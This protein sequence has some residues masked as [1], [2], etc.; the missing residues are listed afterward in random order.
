VREQGRRVI[1]KTLDSVPA[2]KEPA[3]R[4]GDAAWP[5]FLY[6]NDVR[7]WRVLFTKFTRYQVCLCDAAGSLLA[8]GHTLPIPWDGT[9]DDLPQ[10]I[11]SIIQRAI[12]AH[13]DSEIPKVLAALAAIVAPPHQGRG[14]SSQL[15]RAMTS[16]AVRY[17]LSGLIAP[18]RPTLKSLYP[19][20]SMQRY[21]TYTR[22]DGS[23][24]DPWIRVHWR[25]G[26]RQLAI[27]PKTL[28]V[29]GTVSEWE[30]W[31][32]HRFPK[33]GSYLVPGALEPITIDLDL[34]LGRY[35]EPN[36]WMHHRV[37]VKTERE[38][39]V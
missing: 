19:L 29:S 17:G 25:L 7:N 24:F 10:S 11:D 37:G 6:H 16:L 26:A 21:A 9:I 35:E 12:Q 5:A 14:L 27:A 4:L 15:V 1:V 39:D 13:H 22:S 8:V 32:G 33:S 30:E 20:M 18:V 3:G 36:I 38:S 28:V 2:L 23:P 31:T 34:N